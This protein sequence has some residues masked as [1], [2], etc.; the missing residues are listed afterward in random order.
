[1]G[2]QIL[3]VVLLVYPLIITPAAVGKSDIFE[4]FSKVWLSE[5][6]NAISMKRMEMLKVFCFIRVKCDKTF[7]TIIPIT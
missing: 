3:L 5:G 2:G 6:D 1:M 4:T 7:S